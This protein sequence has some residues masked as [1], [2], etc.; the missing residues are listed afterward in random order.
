VVTPKLTATKIAQ[1]YRVKGN[2]DRAK[3][4][5]EHPIVSCQM[6]RAASG[7]SDTLN[8]SRIAAISSNAAFKS[9]DSRNS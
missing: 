4:L 8:Q 6:L 5:E 1:M 2:Y 9:G 3:T 7:N